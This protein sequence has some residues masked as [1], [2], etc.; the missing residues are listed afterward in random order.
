[1]S[2][3]RR[4]WA[5]L[6]REDGFGLMELLI[7]I[8]ILN[9]GIFA[10]MSAFSS[11]YVAIKRSKRVSSGSVLVDQQMERFRALSFQSICLSTT[12]SGD[13]YTGNA[14][15]GTAVPTCTTS[16]PAL[17]ARR[18]PVTGPDNR[19]Y[20]VDTYVVWQC[21]NGTLSTSSPNST[22]S[23]ACTPASGGYGANP[24]KLVRVVVRDATTTSKIW[25][26]EESTFDQ[27]T[28]S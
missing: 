20:R 13:T 18:T 10:V 7:A 1:M 2:R 21:V 15:T 8:T 11:S 24:T 4:M 12:G 17:V 28:S 26:Q 6:A 23:P 5:R 27:G 16:D 22:S 19:T 25:A 3:L 14:P 9:V